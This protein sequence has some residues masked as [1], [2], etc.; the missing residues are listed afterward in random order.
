MKV[1]LSIF[2]L[3][4]FIY[5]S[6]SIAGRKDTLPETKKL[7]GLSVELALE[8]IEQEDIG[9]TPE[10]DKLTRSNSPVNPYADPKEYSDEEIKYPDSECLSNDHGSY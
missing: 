2:F 8:L 1:H 7:M 4:M 9:L 3:V 5:C 10:Q 6:Q